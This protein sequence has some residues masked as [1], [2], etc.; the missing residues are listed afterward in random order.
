MKDML[1]L[2]VEVTAV[3]LVIA[4]IIGGLTLRPLSRPLSTRELRD[5][6]KP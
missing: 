2:I 6:G 5:A 1:R 3:V 4:A